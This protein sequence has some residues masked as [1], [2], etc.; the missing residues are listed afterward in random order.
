MKKLLLVS[1]LMISWVYADMWE[2]SFH[3][4]NTLYHI[5]NKKT[6]RH[7]LDENILYNNLQYKY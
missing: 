5:S 7:Y 2:T 1:F 4:G 3:Q 6:S